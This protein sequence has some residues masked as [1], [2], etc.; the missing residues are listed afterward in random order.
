[1]IW[2]NRLLQHARNDFD[3]T[4]KRALRRVPIGEES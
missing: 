4:E 1:M 2:D 3:P